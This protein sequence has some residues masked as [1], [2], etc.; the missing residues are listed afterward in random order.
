MKPK[1]LRVPCPNLA[2]TLCLVLSILALPSH[3]A[4]PAESGILPLAASSLGA[5]LPGVSPHRF[6]FSIVSRD[7]LNAAVGAQSRRFGLF[8]ADSAVDGQREL[9]H[10]LPFGAI[11][12]EAGERNHVDPLLL[13][14]VVEAES[15]F[16]PRAVSR[17]GAVGLMQLLPSTGHDFG[18]K[19]LRDPYANIDA[20]S[21]LL[22]RLL[23]R[24]KDRT[25]LA[26]AAYN[27][28]PECVARYG[29]VPPYR[30]TQ[31]FVKRVLT[32]Y[33]EHRSQ[34]AQGALVAPAVLARP[35]WHRP[36]WHRPAR[37]L[38]S[39]RLAHHRPPASQVEMVGR[40]AR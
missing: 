11:L 24:F 4:S 9:V 40:A 14:A 30:E 31:D 28:G 36:P 33:A 1:P 8:R 15:R 18:V 3:L 6:D 2:V 22:R 7:D 29:R 17:G 25:D 10:R 37:L 13:A 34:L 20:G 26:L 19:D 5:E 27:T 32:R 38:A 23:A 35:A 21:R 39:S 12:A 16:A